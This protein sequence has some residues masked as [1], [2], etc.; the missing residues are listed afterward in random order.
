MFQP[1]QIRKQAQRLC[2]A[3]GLT[4]HSNEKP[5]AHLPYDHGSLE[6]V[7]TYI[8]SLVSEKVVHPRLIGNFDQVWSMRFRPQRKTYMK[9]SSLRGSTKDPHARSS[10]LRKIRHCLERSLD[11]PLTEPD[12]SEPAPPRD[13][14]TPRVTGGVAASA[15]VD[16][17]RMPRTV[18]T[19]SFCDGHLGRSFVSIRAGAISEELRAKL[20]RELSK[21]L[22]IDEPQPRSHVW[23]Q[24]TFLRYLDFLGQEPWG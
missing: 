24:E 4:P 10:M 17:W 7:R 8:G 14:R 21:H 12:P 11:L 2:N 23:T 5:G 9:E 16:E 1:K 6:A 20:N 22:V 15:L 13:F 18:C 19:L 3:F